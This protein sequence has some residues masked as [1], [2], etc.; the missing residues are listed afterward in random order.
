VVSANLC[1]IFEPS[2]WQLLRRKFLPGKEIAA[3]ARL[4][5]HEAWLAGLALR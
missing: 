1:D 5:L 4:I 2:F 3:K